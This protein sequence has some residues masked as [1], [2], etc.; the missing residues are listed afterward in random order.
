MFEKVEILF[1]ENVTITVKFEN[2]R[3]NSIFMNSVKRYICDVKHSRN[4]PISV[5][6]SDLANL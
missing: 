2:F 1:T 6:G 4:L 5:K 3:E